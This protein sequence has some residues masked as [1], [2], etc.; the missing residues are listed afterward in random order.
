MERL[1]SDEERIRRAEDVLERRRNT[2][3]RI[4]SESFVKE[5]SDSKVKK[6][7]IQLLVCIIIYCVIFY[8]RNAENENFKVFTDKIVS[9]LEYDVDFKKV[10]DDMCSNFEK[11]NTFF[12]NSNS[13]D[14]PNIENNNKEANTDE[15]NSLTDEQKNEAS[16]DNQSE[17]Q[18]NINQ[19]DENLGIGG[20]N[21]DVF[22]EEVSNV[23]KVEKDEEYVK[24]NYNFIKPIDNYKVTSEF[25]MRDSNEI[26]S[27]NHKGIDLGAVSGTNINASLEGEVIEA[28]SIGDFGK[29]LKIKTD[30]IVITY[31]HCSELCVKK[32]D[33]VLQGQ[34]IAEVGSTGKATGPH[35]HFEIRINSNAVNPRSIMDF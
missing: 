29:H 27:A 1:I 33:K 20:A 12:N 3:L 22:Q 4:S 23:E 15:N 9:V 11:I 14:Q 8:V 2:D 5:K 6:M 28:S 21:D 10:Y 25:G 7:L 13:S 35:L 19:V 34:K 16:L 30:D 26:V 18:E 17:N 31:A 24:S 32:G